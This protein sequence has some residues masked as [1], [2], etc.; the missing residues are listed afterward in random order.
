MHAEKR[1]HLFVSL[2]GHLRTADSLEGAGDGNEMVASESN[3]SHDSKEPQPQHSP[4]PL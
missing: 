1:W 3:E 2:Q 4:P